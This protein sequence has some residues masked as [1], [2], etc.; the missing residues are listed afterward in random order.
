MSA[1][2]CPIWFLISLVKAIK[3]RPGWKVGLSKIM[4]PV[5]T[6]AIV[7]GNAA[8]QFKIA[9]ANAERIIT[10]CEQFRA[11]TGKYPDDLDQ[12]VPKYLS[13]VPRAKYALSFDGFRY[14]NRDGN[15]HLMWT[16]VPPFG[17]EVY[18]FESRKWRS[19]D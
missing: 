17:R 18:D 5:L 9:N 8:L 1:I 15:Q 3:K 13:S 16:A 2:V 4:I 19:V 12:L 10:A 6:L 7:G 14:S 11:A